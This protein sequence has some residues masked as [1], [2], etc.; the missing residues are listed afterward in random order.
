MPATWG[1]GRFALPARRPARKKNSYGTRRTFCFVGLFVGGVEEWLANQSVFRVLGV[2]K[3]GVTGKPTAPAAVR[4]MLRAR[5]WPGR[6]ARRIDG[7]S[8]HA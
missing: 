4:L 6:A 8:R 3:G 1:R 7:P 5:E 2:P